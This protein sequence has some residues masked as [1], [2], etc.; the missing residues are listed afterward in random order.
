MFLQHVSLSSHPVLPA[1]TSHPTLPAE[2]SHPAL[3]A[4]ASHRL[5]FAGCSD[6]TLPVLLMVFVSSSK[7]SFA[8]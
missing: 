1:V 8:L 6:P 7:S 3:S 2:R 4:E 5:L